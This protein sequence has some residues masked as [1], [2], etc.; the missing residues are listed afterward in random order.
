MIKKISLA[1]LVIIAG[2]GQN[3]VQAQKFTKLKSGLEYNIV[4]DAPGNTKAIVGSMITMHIRTVVNG[5]ALFDSYTMNNNEPVPAQVAKPQYNGDV[6]EGLTLLT[7]GDS[8]VFRTPADSLF[9]NGSMP[10]NVKN[11]DTVFFYVK[12]I[13][14]QSKAD[15]DKQ[16]LEKAAKQISVDDKLL[17][18]YIKKNNLKAQKTASGIYYVINRKG[19]G[20]HATAADRVKVHYKGYKLNGETFDSSYDRGEPI[21]FPLSGVIKGWTEGI[22]LFEEGGK[23]TLLIPSSLA[24]GPNA[25]QGGKIGPNEVLL[26]DV[27]L[28][29]INP[30]KKEASVAPAIDTK[31][32]AATDDKLIREYI[33]KN[34]LKAEKTA[35]G[36]YY[37]IDRKG[38]GKHATAAD[39]VKVHYKGYKLNGETFDS[40]YDRGQ[41]IEFPLG[42]VI[43]GWT[44]GIPLFEEGG[45]GILLIPSHLAYGPNAPQGAKIGP[46]EVLL[47][48]VELLEINP[49]KQ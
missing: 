4:V 22:P 42:G 41:P 28:L 18:D 40:S 12:M 7:A 19:N 49:V 39:R 13:S 46:N 34:N 44:E 14:V 9:R 15:Y 37:V 27:E 21:E 26:F 17:Q 32:I 3:E 38:N 33:E 16:Q 30:V 48:D 11:T 20:K 45:K 23:G 31:Q 5:N 10:P 36:L 25:P 8:A 43:K 6:M 2:V 24:Y 35:S 1:L 29:E 47:F